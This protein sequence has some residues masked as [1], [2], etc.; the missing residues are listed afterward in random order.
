[1]GVPLGLF[2]RGPDRAD[3]DHGRERGPGDRR[4]ADTATHR[5]CRH[6]GRNLAT[7]ARRC[8][9]CGGRAVTYEVA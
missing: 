2:G 6:C 1:M 9:N 5:E 8:G 4:E 7:T 3:D